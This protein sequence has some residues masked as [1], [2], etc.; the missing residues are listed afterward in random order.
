MY[1]PAQSLAYATK[2]C[3]Y[4][5]LCIPSIIRSFVYYMPMGKLFY[6]NQMLLFKRTPKIM[7]IYIHIL[8]VPTQTYTLRASARMNAYRAVVW[9]SL[10]IPYTL[11][12]SLCGVWLT[13]PHNAGEADDCGCFPLE[14]ART[15]AQTFNA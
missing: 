15:L 2:Q 3:G 12:Y 4:L 11:L 13:V 10:C 1:I 5:Y 7:I 14:R 8:L 9:K 6:E